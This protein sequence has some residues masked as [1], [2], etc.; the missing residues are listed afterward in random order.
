MHVLAD[1]ALFRELADRLDEVESAVGAGPGGFEGLQGFDSIRHG[2]EIDDLH[3]A[4]EGV[5]LPDEDDGRL[6]AIVL[7]FTRPV[8][9]IQQSTFKPSVDGF[10]ESQVMKARLT[11]AQAR[12]EAAAGSV[13]RIELR[14]HRLDWVGTGWMVAP[15][16]AVTNRH[17]AEYFAKEAAGAFP[18]RK[19]RD[20]RVVSATLDWRREYQQP[21]ELLARI[22]EVLWIEPD[23]GYDAALLRVRALDGP[24]L[25]PPVGL[26]TKDEVAATHR[27]WVAVMGYP[28]RS[29]VNDADDQQRIF[30]GIYGVKRLAPGTVMS[31]SPDGLLDHDA[32]TL[33]GNSGS[34]VLHLDSGKA[35][36]LHFGGYEGERNMAVQAWVIA[37]LLAEHG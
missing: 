1:E 5:G 8:L 6:E 3:R 15:D 19:A 16:V 13:G 28:Q 2:Y 14:N 36:G 11:A 35:V 23:E 32:T 34:V 30:D 22:E 10:P 37:D 9:L 26:M 7:K 4:A 18:F 25:P 29:M 33:G 27:S 20:Q 21:D 12:I 24:D 17:V 31:L